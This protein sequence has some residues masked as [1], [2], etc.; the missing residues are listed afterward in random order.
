MCELFGCC[1]PVY[2]DVM[3]K[4]RGHIC[5]RVSTARRC[6]E[7]NPLLELNK[8]SLYFVRIIWVALMPCAIYLKQ[9]TSCCCCCS[10]HMDDGRIKVRSPGILV[11]NII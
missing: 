2:I 10:R 9:D 6:A 5:F 8:S 3:L 11:R 7:L 4:R 1:I